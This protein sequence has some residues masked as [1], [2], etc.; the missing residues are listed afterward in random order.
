MLRKETHRLFQRPR[1]GDLVNHR[2]DERGTNRFTLTV[3]F[4]EV[5]NEGDVV[6]DVGLE[7]AETLAEF[8]CRG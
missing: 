2:F 4:P 1:G 3:A 6:S 7:L 8:V 5:R